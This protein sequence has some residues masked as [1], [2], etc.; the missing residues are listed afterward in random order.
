MIMLHSSRKVSKWNAPFLFA[1]MEKWPSMLGAVKGE[2]STPCTKAALKLFFL[3]THSH[4]LLPSNN[5]MLLYSGMFEVLG[6][7]IA[8]AI[9]NDAPINIPL[10][11]AVID[12]IVQKP[13]D[14][15]FRWHPGSGPTTASK[16]GIFIL[17]FVVNYLQK[18]QTV[19]CWYS[20]FIFFVLLA[21]YRQ[22]SILSRQFGV[23]AYMCMHNVC[24][25]PT[26]H[27]IL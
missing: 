5:E 7:I 17:P 24:I 27:N 10:H 19:L 23:C 15:I 21:V 4:N 25:L 22:A 3:G 16:R 14:E 13:M 9:I 8:A 6:K 26:V 18:K 11:P 1:S 12:F 20:H 2:L